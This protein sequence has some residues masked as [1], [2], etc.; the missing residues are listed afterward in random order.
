M[1]RRLRKALFSNALADRLV[2]FGVPNAVSNAAS[3]S[4]ASAASPPKDS[5][6]ERRFFL[7]FVEPVRL[8]AGRTTTGPSSSSAAALVGF[9]LES[10]GGAGAML[11]SSPSEAS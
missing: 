2:F 5:R 6:L 10:G 9:G 3:P 11:L 7:V 4:S 1:G 8:R